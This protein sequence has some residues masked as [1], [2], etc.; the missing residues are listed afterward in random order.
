MGEYTNKIDQLFEMVVKHGASDLHLKVGSPPILRIHQVPQRTKGQALTEEM[1]RELADSIMSDELREDFNRQGSA[2][3]AYS[4]TGMSRFRVSVYQQRGLVSVCARRVSTKIP[5]LEELHLPQGLRRVPLWGGTTLLIASADP[6]LA[7]GRDTYLDD[8]LAALG[9]RNAVQA[10]GWL[11]LSLEDVLRLDPEAIIIV[12]D[13]GPAVEAVDAAGPLGDLDT[14]ARRR[15]RIVVLQ[16]PD[17]NLPSSGVIG[18]AGEMRRVLRRL[19]E[20]S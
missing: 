15:G 12:R 20:P 13:H 18:L 6:V 4:L 16:H 19:A 14:T 11:E 2:D 10:V 9:G 17:A 3:F 5:T 8:I 1:V 7:V